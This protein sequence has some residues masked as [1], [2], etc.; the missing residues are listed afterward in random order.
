MGFLQITLGALSVKQLEKGY[1]MLR[2]IKLELS[3]IKHI[4]WISAG[5]GVVFS[6]VMIISYLS[7]WDYYTN[8]DIWVT[9]GTVFCY[10]YPLF[11][12][13]P[14][15]WLLYY[16]R[17]NHFLAYTQTRTPKVKYLLSKY[18]VTG[19]GGGLIVFV[20]SLIPVLIS[21]YI[22]PDV[23]PALNPIESMISS[24]FQGE[25]YVSHPFMYG[26][27]LSLWR[28]VIGFLIASFGF[29]L[30]LYV[31]NLFIIF[32]FPFIYTIGENIIMSLMDLNRYMLFTSFCPPY[33]DGRVIT[34][35][36]LLVGPLILVIVIAITI[37]YFSKIKKTKV[38][39]I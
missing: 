6:V 32:T 22:V 18:L 9:S 37:L 29:V 20:I 2:L 23:G 11:A 28:F 38:F 10:I 16:E 15:C 34:Y 30:S 39:E 12:V 31:K 25:Y 5:I 1:F 13:M 21:L 14:V 3:K 17:K 26:F 4:Y 7:G 36:G 8:L 33:M 24:T 27:I 19:L 35:T